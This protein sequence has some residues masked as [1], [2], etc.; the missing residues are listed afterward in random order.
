MAPDK[1]NLRS[2]TREGRL[3]KLTEA[4][5]R[6]FKGNSEEVSNIVEAGFH[7]AGMLRCEGTVIDPENLKTGIN[8]RISEGYYASDILSGVGVRL[9]KAL[10]LYLAGE[11]NLPVEEQPPIL[12]GSRKDLEQRNAAFEQ[13]F[14]PPTERVAASLPAE[15]PLTV[16]PQSI[17]PDD[18]LTDAR[19]EIFCETFMKAKNNIRHSPAHHIMAKHI[20]TALDAK[21]G[22]GPEFAWMR[23]IPDS[24]IASSIYRSGHN[25]ILSPYNKH[26]IRF[27]LS[28]LPGT[29]PSAPITLHGSD[30]GRKIL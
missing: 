16:A 25:E 24:L 6:Y 13:P 1:S 2:S 5:N 21:A 30:H 17:D 19:F 20:R 22:S 29:V 4:F 9:F 23:R 12:S 8:T 28:P 10:T 26:R 15:N 11:P 7:E 27:Q 14:V 3:E 18:Q